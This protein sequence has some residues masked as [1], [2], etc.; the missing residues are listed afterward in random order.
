MNALTQPV[1]APTSQRALTSVAGLCAMVFAE[2]LA[3]GLPLPVLPEHVSGALGFGPFV[4]G[5]A[6]GAQSWAT[7][8]TRPAAGI[9]SDQRGPQSTAVLGL[10][11]SALAGALMATSSFVS[12]AN[13]SLAVLLVGRGLL[14]LGESLVIT[15]ALSWG[16]GLA[17]RER[18][19]LV[20][21]WVGI[22]MY[23]A[24]AVGAP[25]GSAL[26]AR[27]GF[28]GVALAAAVAPLFGLI[29]ALQTKTI[30]TV[31]TTRLPLRTV[32]RLI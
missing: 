28:V 17:G 8:L 26:F 31:G 13:P 20:M 23:G 25:I 9:R 11:L 24:L 16:V 27:F 10:A 22:A 1:G 7:L 15:S 21:A 12:A 18:T 5:L 32:A 30:A 2:F 14:G 6:I 3:M 19:G 4:V 29:A